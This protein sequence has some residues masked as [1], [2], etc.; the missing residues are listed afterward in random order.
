MW[1]YLCDPKTVTATPE[2]VKGFINMKPCPQDRPLKT[3]RLE[4]LRERIKIGQFDIPT[5]ASILVDGEEYRVN[6]KHTSIV[7][8]ELGDRSSDYKVT[9]KQYVGENMQDVAD[10][11]L[12]Y[13][14]PSSS[15]S[16]TELN[17]AVV[18]CNGRLQQVSPWVYNLA[19]PGLSMMK[20]GARYRH[21]LAPAD[22][23]K[24]LSENEDFV[25]WLERLLIKQGKDQRQSTHIA[26]VPVVSVIASTWMRWPVETEAFWSSVRDGSNL[27]PNSPERVLE[28]LLMR[29]IGT[30]NKYHE[31]DVVHWCVTAW[32]CWVQG[33]NQVYQNTL[34]MGKKDTPEILAPIGCRLHTGA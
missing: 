30:R 12:L 34:Y 14:S 15:R 18:A 31:R 3:N 29:T 8:G 13:D 22:R 4:F 24:L 23:A 19:S 5:W 11:Y 10:A 33:N 17:Q 21:K 6:G 16:T 7:L 28:T 32:N 9:L 26:R 20:G 2:L 25:L 1:K 27:N